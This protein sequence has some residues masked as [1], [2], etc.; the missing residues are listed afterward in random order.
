MS[1]VSTQRRVSTQDVSTQRHEYS[2]VSI[3]GVGT[4]LPLLTSS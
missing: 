4:H 1:G 3:P 2:G